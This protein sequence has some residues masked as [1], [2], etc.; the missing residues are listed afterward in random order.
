VSYG[1]PALYDIPFDTQEA[2]T[3]RRFWIR[4]KNKNLV[5]KT[6]VFLSGNT[7]YHLSFKDDKRFTIKQL[8]AYGLYMISENTLDNH[9]FIELVKTFE[10]EN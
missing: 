6:F 1:I 8:D 3:D 4:E 2:N 5:F 10:S 7:N 9:T